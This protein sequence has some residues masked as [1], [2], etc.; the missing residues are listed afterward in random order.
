MNEETLHE[1]K[2][3]KLDLLYN[4][5]LWVLALFCLALGC[6]Y[7]IRL[8]GVLSG[9]LWRFDLMPWNWRVLCSAFAVLYPIAACGL[10]MRSQWGVILWMVGGFVESVC[11]TFYS[12]YFGLNLFIPLLHTVFIILYTV[13]SVLRWMEKRKHSEIIAEY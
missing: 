10:W 11:F 8:I 3:H 13:L 6:Y 7:W 1:I 4:V 2:I 5:F 12:A 9:P